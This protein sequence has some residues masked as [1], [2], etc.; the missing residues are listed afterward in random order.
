MLYTEREDGLRS[1]S[2]RAADKREGDRYFRVN[3]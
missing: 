2:V 3:S 1:I